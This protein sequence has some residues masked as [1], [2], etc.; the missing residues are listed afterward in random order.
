MLTATNDDGVWKW[1]YYTV[2]LARDRGKTNS[3]VGQAPR[4]WSSANTAQH[5]TT[6][7]NTSKCTQVDQ[8]A[9]L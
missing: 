6:Q 3:A 2:Y 7:H 5:N 4:S 9:A 1:W 8:I